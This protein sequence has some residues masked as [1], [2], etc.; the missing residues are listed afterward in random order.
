M[1][2]LPTRLETHPCFNGSH[3]KYGRIHLPVA[4]QCNLRCNYC[5]R[6]YHCVNQCRPG[7]TARLMTPEEAIAFVEEQ[8]TPENNLTVAG[9]AGPGEPLYNDETFYT[10]KRMKEKFPK[11][12]RCVSTNGLLLQERMDALVDC[13][14]STI[15][16]TLNTLCVDTAMKIY[17]GMTAEE[18]KTFLKKQRKG[19][20]EAVRAGM[21]LKLNTVLIPQINDQEIKEIA[22]FAKE[23]KV[24]VMNIM[25]LIPQ[26]KFSNLPAPRDEEITKA[27]MTAG[28]YIEQISHCKRCRADAVG[29][30]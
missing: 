22:Y 26:G 17:A 27:R 20:D 8:D 23:H 7:V 6:K 13:G 12:I 3:H 24:S 1:S 11:L 21:V 5:D 2:F 4:K 14:V 10:F 9:I 28:Q 29:I 25:P 15:T 19:L 30:L 16:L 18:M